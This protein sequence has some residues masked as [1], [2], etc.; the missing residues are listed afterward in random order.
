M[1]ASKKLLYIIFSIL[2]ATGVCVAVI[3]FIKKTQENEAVMQIATM[4][5]S[6]TP[7]QQFNLLATNGTE[8]TQNSLLGQWS[9]IFFG[10]TKC[11]DICPKTLNIVRN[12]WA[13]LSNTKPRPN[14]QFIFTDISNSPVTIDE[15]KEFLQNYNPEFIGLSGST[16]AVH[17]LSDQLGIY[18]KSEE[19]KIDHTAALMLIDP[20]GRLQAVFTPPFSAQDILHDLTILAL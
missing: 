8:F 11:P 16:E 20:Q 18:T 17:K 14:V 10:Y 1:I 2:L 15:L 19:N 5:K 6:P 9:L 4:V 3:T 13:M 7:L 12:T